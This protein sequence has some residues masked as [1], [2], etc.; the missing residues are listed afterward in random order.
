MRPKNPTSTLAADA[1]KLAVRTAEGP[2]R[3]ASLI[4]VSSQAISQWEQVPSTRVIQVERATGIP[5][6]AL[7]P[8][9]YPP[10]PPPSPTTQ[11]AEA[12]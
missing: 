5:R 2:T 4:G 9:L 6:H 11:T 3:L 10:G 12:R 8:D 7:R 1:L